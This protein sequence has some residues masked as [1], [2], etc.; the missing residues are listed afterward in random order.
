MKSVKNLSGN[1]WFI[2]FAIAMIALIISVII[3]IGKWNCPCPCP[4]P[5]PPNPDSTL[6][7]AY[8]I[9]ESLA[10]TEVLRYQHFINGLASKL[11]VDSTKIPLY[12]TID[13]CDFLEAM[14][15]DHLRREQVPLSKRHSRIYISMDRDS[16]LHLLFTPVVGATLD[17]CNPFGAILGKDSV[18]VGIIPSPL[19]CLSLVKRYGGEQ[20]VDRIFGKKGMDLPEAKML[21]DLNAPCPTT[22]LTV[23][24]SASFIYQQ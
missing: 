10:K 11:Q 22:C 18:R 3:L 2:A 1:T 12:F 20:A 19:P 15:I 14:G 13:N 7:A 23:G 4:P 17:N 8:H 9:T 16:M 6:S 24:S 5:P 21:V